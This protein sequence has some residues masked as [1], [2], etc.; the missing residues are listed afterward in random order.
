MNNTTTTTEVKETAAISKTFP[1]KYNSA[2]KVCGEKIEVGEMI[3]KTPVGYSHAGCCGK[4]ITAAGPVVEYDGKDKLIDGKRSRICRRDRKCKCCGETI[5]AGERTTPWVNGPAPKSGTSTTWWV[6]FD[7]SEGKEILVPKAGTVAIPK[8]TAATT[9]GVTIDD[10]NRVIRE[11]LQKMDF[12]KID[13]SIDALVKQQT[14]IEADRIKAELSVPREVAVTTPDGT[15]RVIKGHVHEAF[16]EVL[17]LAS[18]RKTI[19]LPGPAGCGKT[20]LA[21]QIAEALGLQFGFI[22]CSERM[23]EGQITGRLVPVGDN[24]SFQYVGTRFVDCFENGGVFLADEVDAADP[25][26]LLVINAALA[27]GILALP[28][29]PEKPVAERHPDFVY[30]AAGNTFGH[31]AD[32]MYVGR[33]ELDEATLDRFKVGTV[34]MDYDKELDRILCPDDELRGYLHGVRDRVSRAGL[35]RLVSSRF[36]KDAHDMKAAGLWDMARVKVALFAGWS[37]DEKSQ[38]GA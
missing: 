17:A 11:A 10:V 33:N 36:M 24:G 4:E 26:V 20:H 32:R 2:C 29:R 22:S 1:S 28:N 13:Q 37:E 7:C 25:N 8:E 31:G 18:M 6:H 12:S 23:S 5:K 21:G 9:G 16:D 30:I 14:K 3:A 34:P 19:F 35:R 27:N 15:R 38:V